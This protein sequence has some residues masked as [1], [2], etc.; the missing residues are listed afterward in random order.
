MIDVFREIY[1]DP[2]VVASVAGGLGEI[3]AVRALV[4]AWLEQLAWHGG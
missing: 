2:V 1:G 3:F 4:H